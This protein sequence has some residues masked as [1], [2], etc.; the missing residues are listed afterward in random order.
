M[1]LPEHDQAPGRTTE[2][3]AWRARVPI[4]SGGQCRMIVTARLRGN[5]ELRSERSSAAAVCR[6]VSK[7]GQVSSAWSSS[8]GVIV[9]FEVKRQGD[10]GSGI[11]RQPAFEQDR[12]EF[13][14]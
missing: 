8:A 11:E 9:I 10:Q 14:R 5:P 3:L 4:V 1:T 6:L 7:I 13:R 2:N 12:D